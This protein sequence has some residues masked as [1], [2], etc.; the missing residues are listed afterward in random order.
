MSSFDKGFLNLVF[1]FKILFDPRN[2]YFDQ[3]KFYFDPHTHAPTQTMQFSRLQK[4][5]TS[6]GFLFSLKEIFELVQ[7]YF[8]DLRELIRTQN[9]RNK[10]HKYSQFK[11]L[12]HKINKEL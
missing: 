3:R 2:F 8:N 6:R 12:I 7:C 9:K 10:L 4:Q 1:K 11:S 5:Q